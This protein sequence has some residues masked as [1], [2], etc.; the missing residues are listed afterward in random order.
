[1]N[2]DEFFSKNYNVIDVHLKEKQLVKEA[3]FRSGFHRQ[4]MLRQYTKIRSYGGLM[5]T[6]FGESLGPC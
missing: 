3:Y 5:Q 1:M 6:R 2:F 4:G